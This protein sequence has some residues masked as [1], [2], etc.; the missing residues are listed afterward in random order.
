MIDKSKTELLKVYVPAHV[1]RGLESA[2]GLAGESVSALACK[3]LS[4][5]ANNTTDTELAVWYLEAAIRDEGQ[6]AAQVAV[7]KYKAKLAELKAVGGVE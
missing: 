4:V 3:I 5:N 1:K 7:A 2:S 6:A